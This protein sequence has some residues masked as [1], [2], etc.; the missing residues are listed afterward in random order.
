[1]NLTRTLKNWKRVI[2]PSSIRSWWLEHQINIEFAQQIKEARAK[3]NHHDEVMRL[4]YEHRWN[5]AEIR[6]ETSKDSRK[7]DSQSAKFHASYTI[8]TKG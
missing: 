7:M 2:I 5:L 8:F 3:K 6:F 4:G 1:M